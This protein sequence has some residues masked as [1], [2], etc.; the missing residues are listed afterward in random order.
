M[1]HP[2][3]DELM[4]P[5]PGEVERAHLLRSGDGVEQVLPDQFI[6]QGWRPCWR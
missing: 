2:R 4:D 3:R 5:G 6:S 1:Y